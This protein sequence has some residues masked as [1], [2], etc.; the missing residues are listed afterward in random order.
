MD[1]MV[2]ESVQASKQSKIRKT[3]KM[4][5]LEEKWKIVPTSLSITMAELTVELRSISRSYPVVFVVNTK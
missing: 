1:Y 2:L 4:S 5:S 3:C